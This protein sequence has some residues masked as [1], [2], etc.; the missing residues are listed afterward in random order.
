MTL[1]HKFVLDTESA[2]INIFFSAQVEHESALNGSPHR[3]DKLEKCKASAGCRS[4]IT[5]AQKCEN[6]IQESW[7]FGR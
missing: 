6:V 3:L 1:W 4:L 2:T 5:A 7:P